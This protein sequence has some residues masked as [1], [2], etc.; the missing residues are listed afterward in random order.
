M[1]D[2]VKLT[3]WG[4][5][6]LGHK[7]AAPN[8]VKLVQLPPEIRTAIHECKDCGWLYV[9]GRLNAA[10]PFGPELSQL[11]LRRRETELCPGFWIAAPICFSPQS[12]ISSCGCP[13]SGS[14]GIFGRD[15]GGSFSIA[16]V[17]TMLARANPVSS[18]RAGEQPH[19]R[20]R[21]STAVRQHFEPL[22]GNARS[23][24]DVL[25]VVEI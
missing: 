17:T 7:I 5:L 3:R 21:I 10:V 18:E 4:L 15:R 16:F 1:V 19:L 22:P 2:E 25:K 9:I 12:S 13:N 14:D 20:Q 23:H 24:G 6:H 8:R 11:G